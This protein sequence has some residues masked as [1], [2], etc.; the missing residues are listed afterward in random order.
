[1]K[2]LIP[3]IIKKIKIGNE[4]VN[5]NRHIIDIKTLDQTITCSVTRKPQ[6]V[7]NNELNIIRHIIELN[8]TCFNKARKETISELIS[9]EIKKNLG[10]EWFVIAYNEAY[11]HNENKKLLPFVIS[12]VEESDMIKFEIGESVFQIARIK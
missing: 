1:M 11:N 7:D 8:Y 12:S 4:I 2:I 3:L 10:G 5:E 9:E 6:G